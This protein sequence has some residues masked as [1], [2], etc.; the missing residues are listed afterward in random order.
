MFNLNAILSAAYAQLAA[1]KIPTGPAQPLSLNGW[2]AYHAATQAKRARRALV[3]KVGRRQAIKIG[4]RI[5]REM[6]AL[7]ASA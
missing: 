5:N 2:W 3:R 6:R 4:K 7:T 1:R